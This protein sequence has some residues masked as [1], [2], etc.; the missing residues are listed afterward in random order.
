MW[1]G[2]WIVASF[3]LAGCQSTGC[4]PLV[5]YG[6]EM[7]KRAAVELRAL[8]KGSAL[9]DM[10]VDYKKTRDAIRACGR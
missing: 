3:S 9:A 8:P 1:R 7:Q 6:P 10:I 4:P 5:R 2:I